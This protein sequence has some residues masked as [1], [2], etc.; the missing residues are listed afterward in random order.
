MNATMVK[1]PDGTPIPPGIP[2][3]KV[4]YIM[5]HL[6]EVYGPMVFG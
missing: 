6:D 1:M 5:T 2:P 4:A 3:E